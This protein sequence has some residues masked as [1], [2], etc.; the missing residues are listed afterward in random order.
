MHE[1][2]EVIDEG[3]HAVVEAMVER[4][5]Q[6]QVYGHVTQRM[7]RLHTLMMGND[8]MTSSDMTDVAMMTL[9]L[10]LLSTVTHLLAGQPLSF[11]AGF[12][13][14]AAPLYMINHM[15]HEHEH[16]IQN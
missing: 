5:K 2:A 11:V 3:V 14:M 16:E 1:M 4:T 9:T 8:T 10:P 12:L 6:N 13:A 15:Q 7:E